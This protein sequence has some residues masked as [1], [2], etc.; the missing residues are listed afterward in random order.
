MTAPTL[1]SEPV[2]GTLISITAN[3]LLLADRPDR[4]LVI[5]S[6]SLMRLEV[7]RGTNRALLWGTLAG[8]VAGGIVT[9]TFLEPFCTDR[10]N[11]CGAGTVLFGV[12][13]LFV[14]TT[15]IGAVLGASLTN[16]RWEEVS[17]EVI[18][19]GGTIGTGP[20]APAGFRLSIS[21]PAPL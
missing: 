13:V 7:S 12:G 17:L 16:E 20:D 9:A 14:P 10:D 19:V 2:T 18:R 11:S 3:S 6:K 8:A 1:F 4:R 21:I 5:P 15:L